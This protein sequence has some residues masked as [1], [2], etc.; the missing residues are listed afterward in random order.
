MFFRYLINTLE[1]VDIFS[2]DK[3]NTNPTELFDIQKEVIKRYIKINPILLLSEYLMEE[4]K[5]KNHNDN[6]NN[7]I[8]EKKS[9]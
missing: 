5:S 8:K 3:F 2:T 1:Q 6:N 9:Y 7:E 4:Y